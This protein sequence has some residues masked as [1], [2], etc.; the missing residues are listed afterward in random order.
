MS[1][2]EF[3]ALGREGGV[4]DRDLG[5]AELEVEV[6]VESRF[7]HSLSTDD[8]LCIEFVF[9]PLLSLIRLHSI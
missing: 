6:E 5:G 9:F 3:A 8:L 4:E 1:G 7:I 2:V